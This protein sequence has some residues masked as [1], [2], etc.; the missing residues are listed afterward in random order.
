M[1]EGKEAAQSKIDRLIASVKPLTA[2]FIQEASPNP[3]SPRVNN[4]TPSPSL[5]KG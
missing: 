5:S 2:A 3:E 4:N 1:Y